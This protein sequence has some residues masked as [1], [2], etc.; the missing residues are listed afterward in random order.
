M[1]A[2][3]TDANARPHLCV[4]RVIPY[5]VKAAAAAL[6]VRANPKN[7][8]KLPAKL[9]G[10]SIHPAKMALFTGKMWGNG[11]K[12]RVRFLDGSV[13]QRTRVTQHAKEWSKYANVTLNFGSAA[14]AEIRV[15]FCADDGSWSA[16]GTDCL[17]AEY[18]K[19]KEPTMNFGWLK[20]ETD[21]VE[22]RRVVIHEFGHAL[23]CIH[24]HQNPAGG[25]KWNTPKVYEVFS[26][27]PNNWSKPE[28]DHNIIE[29][30]SM[31]QLNATKFDP[32]S[33][34]LYSFPPELIVGGHGTSNNSTL[35]TG[36]KRYIEKMYMKP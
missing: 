8:P 5:E 36:D 20:D 13:T 34:M 27:P 15:S 12:L 14:N 2:N 32:K 24:E 4:D 26:G 18:F 16:I 10:V 11:K 35:S 22:Y 7:Q 1:T 29:K 28:I 31:D 23:G 21:D 9:A 3:K 17:Y 6:A 19:P 30:Y 25:I 33:I